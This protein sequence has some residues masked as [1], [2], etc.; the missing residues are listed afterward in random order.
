[1]KAEVKI[2]DWDLLIEP[3]AALLGYIIENS[4]VTTK[5]KKAGL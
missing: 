2:S 4:M 3:P 5:I 1:M